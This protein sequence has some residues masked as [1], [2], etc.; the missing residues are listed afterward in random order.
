MSIKPTRPRLTREQW[1]EVKRDRLANLT[2]YRALAAKYGVSDAAIIK[3][4]KAEDWESPAAK[5]AN[6]KVSDVIKQ[7]S[8]KVSANPKEVSKQPKPI[9]IGPKNPRANKKNK[10]NKV[11]EPEPVSV[12]V[13]AEPKPVD[14][15]VVEVSGCEHGDD[16]SG[17]EYVS[18]GIE[19]KG[20]ANTENAQHTSAHTE[21]KDP[22][23]DDFA[24]GDLR[25]LLGK[26]G[27]N[28]YRPEYAI[29]ALRFTMLG[30]TVQ[31]L[32]DCIGVDRTTLYN[33]RNKYPEFARALDGGRAL[34][35]ANVASRLYQRAMGYTHESEEIKVV[36]DQ[37]HRVPVI[38]HYAPDTQSL[39]FWLINRQPN[40]WK[41]RVEVV[42][43]PVI[44]TIDQDAMDRMYEKVLKEAEV[45]REALQDRGGR[46]GLTLDGDN[47]I[48]E[49]AI[50]V[51]YEEIDISEMD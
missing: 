9:T 1:D 12:E 29:V 11:S 28:I 24:Y 50:D 48:D 44:T 39:K 22:G 34:A 42:E 20:H 40:L 18:E 7:V 15:E 19:E 4:S 2:P 35:D 21:A 32:A 10:K 5:P 30:A 38:K 6:P 51:E 36:G 33:W 16:F 23:M 31:E 3:R 46:L 17:N 41:E 47:P 25:S 45:K 8:E 13:I 37:V 26:L 49:P 27:T 43:K 14:T